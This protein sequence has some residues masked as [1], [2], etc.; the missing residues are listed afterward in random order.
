MRGWAIAGL[1]VLLAGCTTPVQEGER[2][3]REG[4]R[5]AAL[6][7]WRSVPEGSDD[8][9]PARAHIAALE[10]E[11][12]RLVVQYEERAA[13]HERQGHLAEA[14]LDYRLALALQPD[15]ETLDHV[16]QLA[17]GLASRRGELERSYAEALEAGDLPAARRSLVELRTLDPFDASLETDARELDQAIQAAVAHDMAEGRS[18]FAAGRHGAASRSFRSVLALEPGNE[19]A[20]GYLSY[21]ATMRRE[22][23]AAA[24]IADADAFATD[25]EMRA[26]GFHQRALAAERRGDPY[27]AIRYELRAIETVPDHPA[28]RRHLADLRQRMSGEVQALVEAGRIAFR[29]EDLESA[30][31][32]W[33]RALLVDPD[34]ERVLAYIGR[35][36]QQIENLERLRASPDADGS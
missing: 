9:A 6:E 33:R 22:R 36:S 19:A 26:E 28:A 31:D 17:R 7:T 24:A 4:D 20:R 23:E 30:L 10:P 3:Y 32:L 14:I 21:I 29:E 35:V 34:N 15:D 25:A 11:F 13:E 8:Y 2:L 5:L 18:A 12:E 16:Q 1:A 27:A